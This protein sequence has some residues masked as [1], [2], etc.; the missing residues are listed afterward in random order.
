[1]AKGPDNGIGRPDMMTVLIDRV[2]VCPILLQDPPTKGSPSL[3]SDR[4]LVLSLPSAF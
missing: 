4:R 2:R 1:M 3:V